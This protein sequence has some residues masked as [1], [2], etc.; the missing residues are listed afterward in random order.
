[1][2]GGVDRVSFCRQVLLQTSEAPPLGESQTDYK[3]EE[4]PHHRPPY[5]LQTGTTWE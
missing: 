4:R 1:M 5:L 2:E 3:Q